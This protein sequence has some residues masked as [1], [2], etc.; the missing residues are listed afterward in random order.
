MKKAY[1]APTS[2]TIQIVAE[3]PLAL[4]AGSGLSEN[5]GLNQGVRPGEDEFNGEFS[6]NKQ[7]WN[8]NDWS[9]EE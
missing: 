9:G 3:G 8:A 7:G 6:S 4:S 5:G 2:E 1:V